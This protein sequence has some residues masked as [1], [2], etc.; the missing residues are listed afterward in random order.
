MNNKI[1][2]I[3]IP[4]YNHKNYIRTSILNAMQLIDIADIVVIDD[5][6]DDGTLD[7]L[8]KESY[9]GVNII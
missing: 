9:P 6:S 4:S 1:L 8:T 5:A 2:T 3:V 7:I